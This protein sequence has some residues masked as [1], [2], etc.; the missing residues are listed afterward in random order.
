MKLVQACYLPGSDI[1]DAAIRATGKDIGPHHILDV[2]EIS[3]SSS[4]FI[5]LSK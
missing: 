5:G 3:N 2:H 1:E 4:A